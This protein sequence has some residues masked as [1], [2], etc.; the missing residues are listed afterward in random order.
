[1][2]VGLHRDITPDRLRALHHFEVTGTLFRPNGQSVHAAMADVDAVRQ[3][4]RW[5]TPAEETTLRLLVEDYLLPEI[6]AELG[7]SVRWLQTN[8]LGSLC[9]KLY[10]VVFPRW[11]QLW[12]PSNGCEEIPPGYIEDAKYLQTRSGMRKYLQRGREEKAIARINAGRIP[13]A[14]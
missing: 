12:W 7:R 6:A 1:M 13:V 3:A 5:L 4:L 11:M 10:G 9:T 14:A 8:V 2:A